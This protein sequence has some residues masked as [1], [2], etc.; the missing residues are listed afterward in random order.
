ML[1][2]RAVRSHYVRRDAVI[3]PRRM[4]IA[5]STSQLLGDLPLTNKLARTHEGLPPARPRIP[6]SEFLPER[7][8]GSTVPTVVAR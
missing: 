6:G 2:F 8:F 1:A 5:R 3:E 4:G 7:I